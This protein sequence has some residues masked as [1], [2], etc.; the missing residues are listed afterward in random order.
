[1]NNDELCSKCGKEIDHNYKNRSWC[2]SCKREYDKQYQ[3][4]LRDKI[5]PD[6]QKRSP[7]GQ[8]TPLCARCKKIKEKPKR[9]YCVEC[10]R[11]LNREFEKKRN[12]P[13]EGKYAEQLRKSARKY[14]EKHADEINLKIREDRKLNPEKY[15]Q[16]EHRSK[17]KD[18]EKSRYMDVLKKHK[19]SSHDYNEMII[20]QEN[21]CAICYKEET[22]KGRNGNLARLCIDHCHQSGKIRALLC[23]D[24]NT[25]IGK[26]KD[27]INLLKAA[28][29][30]LEKHNHVE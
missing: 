5:N 7:R 19:I 29:T 1:M 13:Y 2:R 23:H 8:I 24:C 17:Y 27:N 21:R 22:R 18:I 6:R 20:S 30:Y 16:Y 9:C 3:R 14:H 11:L 10:E 28:I 4:Q 12:R 25:G 15:K 26:F